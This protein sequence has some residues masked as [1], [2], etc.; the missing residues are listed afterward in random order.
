MALVILAVWLTVLGRENKTA[1]LSSFVVMS[2]AIG[3]RLSNLPLAIVLLIPLL[4]RVIRT[5]E[6]NWPLWFSGMTLFVITTL[7]WLTPMVFLAGGGIEQYLETVHKQWSMTVQPTSVQIT[8]GTTVITTLIRIER[9]VVGYFVTYP[10]TGIYTNSLPH[11]FLA[12][13]SVFGFA[14]FIVSFRLRDFRHLLAL[15]WIIPI[16]LQ[17]TVIHFL[18]RYG[19]P[20]WPGFMFACLIGYHFLAQRLTRHPLRVEIFCL[21]A[22]SSLL[23]VYGIKHQAPLRIFESTI[24]QP[25]MV[26]VLFI[27]LGILGIAVCKNIIGRVEFEKARNGID[28]T[29]S[30]SSTHT[31]HL[32]ISIVLVLLTIPQLVI[33][34][35]YVLLA[36]TSQSPIEQMVTVI[37]ETFEAEE[38][39]ACWD[40]QT[41]SLLEIRTPDI[42]ITRYAS[43]DELLD[44]MKS[45]NSMLLFTDR[46]EWMNELSA[47][48]QY[49]E[50]GY[51][52]GKNPLWVK[53]PSI[54]LYVTTKLAGYRKTAKGC[55]ELSGGHD[56]IKVIQTKD[57]R[58]T[59]DNTPR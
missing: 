27:V 4:E 15:A 35:R 57:E 37:K 8:G 50:I 54:H 19:L 49:R 23:I 18:P 40:D 11:L 7:A 34:Y 10:P 52:E 13:P 12:I 14:L 16:I 39:L 32:T 56:T 38:M 30:K 48:F 6:V 53:T 2:L 9:F 29:P 26:P 45:R 44:K 31:I 42:D 25:N 20:Y 22:I 55:G 59:A 36:Q 24:S 58:C 33:G 5:R 1:F 47:K 21:L 51:F 17:S 28:Q 46:C 43:I 3:V 41:H